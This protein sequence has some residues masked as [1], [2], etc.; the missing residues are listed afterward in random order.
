MSSNP[1]DLASDFPGREQDIHTL[2]TTNGHFAKLFDSYDEL[3]RTIHRFETRVEPTTEEVE[4]EMKR[5]RVRIKD[6][7]MTMLD[8]GN[9]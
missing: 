1:N 5:R 6:E 3:N 9:A 2:K 7:I 8:G 4:E